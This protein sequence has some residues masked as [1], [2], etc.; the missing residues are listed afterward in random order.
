M[1]AGVNCLE[2]FSGAGGL[3]MGLHNARF[4][5]AGLVEFN[6]D[7]CDTMR[8]NQTHGLRLLRGWNLVESDTRAIPDFSERFGPVD[9]VAGGPPCQPFSIGGKARGPDDGRDLFPEAVRAVRQCRPLGFVFENVKGLL[10]EGFAPYFR[11]VILQLTYPTVVRKR[12]EPAGEHCAR[13]EKLDARGRGPELRYRVAWRTLNA[14]D[15]GV[16]QTRERVFIVG[17]RSEVGAAWAFPDPTHSLAE[18]ERT[19]A[20]CEYF[21]RHASERPAAAGRGPGGRF[22]WLTV[23]DA[24]AGLPDPS[25]HPIPG[26]N[27]VLV[28]GARAYPRHTGSPLDLPAKTLKAGGHGVPGGENMLRL[29]DGRVRYFTVREAAR[30]QTF[31]DAYLFPSS[32]T[33]TMRQLGNAVPVRLGEV[34]ARGVGAAL[35]PYCRARR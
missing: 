1:K 23:R 20:S 5:H 30:L 2:L 10:R 19:L 24:L 22:P 11:Y 3:A 21:D 32:W 28:D 15:Y 26:L 29:P 16:P 31:S 34:V 35:L 8:H 25:L 13:L 6:R 12:S 33:A 17:F 14:A 9:L 27:H 18:L 7:A 4:R